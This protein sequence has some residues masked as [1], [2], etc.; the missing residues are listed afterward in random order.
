MPHHDE[1]MARLLSPV[2]PQTITPSGS[3]FS[4][5][6]ADYGNLIV[7][8]GTVSLLEVG[9]NGTFVTAGVLAGF[10]PVARGDTVRLTYV[11]APSVSFWK[12]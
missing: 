10:V 3:P 2:A 7:S 12:A 5:V 4:W 1:T 8:G 9:R 6:S 11:V